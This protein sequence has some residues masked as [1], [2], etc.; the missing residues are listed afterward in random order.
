MCL[1]NR[2]LRLFSRLLSFLLRLIGLS[3]SL[4][5]SCAFIIRII[6]NAF[7]RLF[8]LGRA[9]NCLVICYGLL[10]I[11]K[12]VLVLSLLDLIR[13]FVAYPIFIVFIS[14][15]LSPNCVHWDLLCLWLSLISID[16][17]LI[18]AN[19]ARRFWPC[20]NMPHFLISKVIPFPKK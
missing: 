7:I 15:A 3:F 2:A 10:T 12:L 5:I 17:I 8:G 16:D 11:F 20:I 18:C 1:F 13:S 19:P 9:L 6:I 4:V 14:I